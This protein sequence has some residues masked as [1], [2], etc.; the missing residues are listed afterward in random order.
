M[1][2][3]LAKLEPALAC[4]YDQPHQ[5]ARSARWGAHICHTEL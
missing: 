2:Q 3:H 4:M 1:R 5:A